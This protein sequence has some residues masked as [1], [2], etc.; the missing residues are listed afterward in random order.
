MSGDKITDESRL[1]GAQTVGVD[2]TTHRSASEAS[3]EAIEKRL[4]EAYLPL[5][6]YLPAS[7]EKRLDV[8]RQ[9]G[10]LSTLDTVEDMRQRFI[11]ENPLDAKTQQL[12]HFAQLLVL[13]HREPAHLHATAAQRAGA[14]PSELLGV[15]ETALITAGMPAYHLGITILATLKEPLERDHAHP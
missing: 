8:A 11:S 5:F 6:G 3:V 15:V 4:K 12:V 7:I 13:S 10:R 9:A 14:S 2:I 1:D